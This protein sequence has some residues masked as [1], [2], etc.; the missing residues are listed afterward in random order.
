MNDKIS[1]KNIGSQQHGEVNRGHHS[2]IVPGQ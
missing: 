1:V 2:G